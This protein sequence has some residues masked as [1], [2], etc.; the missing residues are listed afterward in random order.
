MKSKIELLSVLAVFALFAVI[1]VPSVSATYP[2]NAVYF[3][4]EDSSA[5]FCANT[6][7]RVMVNTSVKT[8]GAGMDIYFD[9]DCVN[10]TGIDFTG[11]PYNNLTNIE[12]S[13]KHWG[14]YIREGVLAPEEA[15]EPGIHLVATLTL[16]CEKEEAECTSD[17]VFT[18]T[19]LVDEE[20]EPLS[21]VTWH[22]GTITCKIGEE[23]DLKITEK[24]VCW[25]D[26]CTICYNVTNIGNGTAPACHNTT[27]YVDGA[28]VAHDHVPVDLAPGE[29]YPGCFNDYEWGY[30][31]PEDNITVCADNNETLDELDETNNCLTN[32]WMCGD[33]NGDRTVN[34]IDVVLIYKRALDP[35]YPL[36]LPWAGDVNCDRNIN[37]IDVVL[38]YKRALDPGYDL[39]CCCEG[40]E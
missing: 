1:A 3:E 2:A 39:N 32:I 17:L 31:P 37:V 13:W 18:E 9:P 28:E 19:E 35:G 27:L 40:V 24:W 30:T 36:D 20:G 22:D 15:V 12:T 11:T 10:I 21:D 7:V 16:H 26:N 34:V 14:N 5:K 38:V 33:V 4:P 29:S 23:P 8:T 6:Y 25:P